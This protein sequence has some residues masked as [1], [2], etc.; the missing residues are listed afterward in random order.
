MTAL[1][2][3]QSPTNAPRM[4]LRD[5]KGPEL[6][7][8]GLLAVRL[9]THTAEIEAAQ[10]LR[11]RVFFQSSGDRSGGADLL[12]SDRFDAYCDHLLVIDEARN[13]PAHERIVGTYR[14][15]REECASIAG[16]YYSEQAFDVHS[17]VNRHPERRFLELGRS[18]VMPQYRSKRTVELLW[19]GIWAYCQAHSIDVMF[20][21]ASF[22]GTVPAAHALALSFLHHHARAAGG[23]CVAA[24]GE[25]RTQMDLMPVEAVGMRDAVNAMPPL[26]KG[27]LRLGA[28]FSDGAVIDREF[29]TTDV[30]V[31]LR[32]E[33]I[34]ARY[35]N[36]FRPEAARYV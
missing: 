28:K 25:T 31:V 21:C 3:T 14:L 34:G 1:I 33:D 4:A 16:G 12:D 26:V 27:Y 30:F 10:R 5:L 19:Q 7:R 18:C 8:L 9:A 22:A 2:A 13:G 6:G 15:L 20:G 23:W 17:L 36:H 29:G 35:L 11:H 32:T 24:I